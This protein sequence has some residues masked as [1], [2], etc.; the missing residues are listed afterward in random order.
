LGNSAVQSLQQHLS[1]DGS[2][3]S[4]LSALRL[5]NVGLTIDDV[6]KVCELCAAHGEVEQLDLS[7]NFRKKSWLSKK[8]AEP[9]MGK[10]TVALLTRCTRL[11]SLAIGAV[12]NER[13][14]CRSMAGVPEAV[15]THTSL[16]ALD[17]TALRLLSDDYDAF[18][19]ALPP[20]TSLLLL[21]L[22]RDNGASLYETGF[23]FVLER[24]RMMAAKRALA[25]PPMPDDE[26]F[27]AVARYA[28]LKVA[29]RFALKQEKL[30]RSTTM[31][32]ASCARSLSTDGK[33]PLV[34][35]L[36]PPPLSLAEESANLEKFAASTFSGV[37]LI[38]SSTTPT[39]VGC[40]LLF[41]AD[42]PVNSEA[43]TSDSCAAP[44]AV[45]DSRLTPVT[46]TRSAEPRK[47]LGAAAAAAKRQYYAQQRALAAQQAQQSQARRT[48]RPTTGGETSDD[49]DASIAHS[50]YS[51]NEQFVRAQQRF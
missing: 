5:S 28:Y 10:A 6:A 45:R 44:S 4:T 38:S 49:D 43:E 20:N 17:L 7:D 31:N 50:D 9:N 18:A 2:G 27:A 26:Y 34:Q 23:E 48:G 13:T 25:T 12:E 40:G 3:I 46:T 41:G 32:K 33:A 14:A 35:T 24:N 19:R 22:R 15:A 37:G 51:N 21:A 36:T 8:S 1:A 16:T 47:P 39:G 30:P 42:S 29:Q 11:R